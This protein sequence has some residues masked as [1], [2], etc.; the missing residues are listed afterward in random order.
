MQSSIQQNISVANFSFGRKT[1]KN[2]NPLNN[3][4]KER[5]WAILDMEKKYNNEDH[6]INKIEETDFCEKCNNLMIY[7]EEGFT[8][9][10]NKECAIMHKYCLDYSPEWRYF[11]NEQKSNNPDT[12]RCGNPI[13]PLLEESSYSCKIMCS[14]SA[15]PEMKKLRKWSKWHSMPHK[16]K[17]L[18]EEFQLI[19]I[20]ATNGG[21]PKLFVDEAKIIFKDLYEQ[22]TFRGMKRDAMRAACIWIACWKN[23][24]PRTPNEI[25]DIFHIDKASASLGCSTA[26]QLL[27]S[28]ER[29]M[30]DNDK[31]ILCTLKPS[32]FIERF[33]SKVN[34]TKEQQL[35]SKFICQKVEKNELI[36]DNRPQAVSAGIIYFV[37]YF[38]NV[39][40]TKMDIKNK[41]GDEASEVT[42]NKCFKKLKEHKCSLLPSWVKDKYNIT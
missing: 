29:N 9:C 40:Y 31:S 15:S 16:E 34:F 27:K 12:T 20:Y 6:L 17:M 19:Q 11:T 21:I 28:H 32:S 37:S 22:K 33:A 23:N 41:L 8:T 4:E 2:K 26:E 38:C 1:K 10:P 7:S 36:P 14:S 30:L 13:D 25:A 3:D 39:G 35:L 18:Y 24:C 5:L 42:I